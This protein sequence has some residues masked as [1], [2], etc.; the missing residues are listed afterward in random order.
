[1][2]IETL[3]EKIE[4]DVSPEE[5]DGRVFIDNLRSE[6]EQSES[7]SKVQLGPNTLGFVSSA[8]NAAYGDIAIN[9]GLTAVVAGNSFLTQKSIDNAPESKGSE[10]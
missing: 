5:Q 3:D 6:I 10:K 2:P 7:Q 9:G 4:G 8:A 1:M